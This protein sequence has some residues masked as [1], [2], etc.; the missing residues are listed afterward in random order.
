MR[1]EWATRHALASRKFN[2]FVD[3]LVGYIY[4]W[5]LRDD[6]RE[7]H[8]FGTRPLAVQENAF[9]AGEHKFSDRRASCGCLL[10]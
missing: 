4:L 8:P 6:E 2:V 1:L 7:S 3:V 9:D 10:F 5:T